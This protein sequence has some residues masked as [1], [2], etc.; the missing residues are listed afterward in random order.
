[1]AFK[2]SVRLFAFKVGELEHV[3]K[4]SRRLNYPREE[5]HRRT[6]LFLPPHLRDRGWRARHYRDSSPSF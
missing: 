1:M 4:L 2:Y 3:K 5:I 6:P